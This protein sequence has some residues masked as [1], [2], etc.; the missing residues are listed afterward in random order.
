M[1][2]NRFI[3]GGTSMLIKIKEEEAAQSQISIQNSV[4]KHSSTQTHCGATNRQKVYF[5]HTRCGPALSS[6]HHTS[7]SPPWL[8]S[9]RGGDK[10]K[11][12]LRPTT[13]PCWAGGGLHKRAAV[14]F[15]LVCVL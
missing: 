3:K 12:A 6:K 7:R 15:T 1:Y 11:Y 2:L 5:Q 4:L 14:S 13:S 9:S 10:A 8:E